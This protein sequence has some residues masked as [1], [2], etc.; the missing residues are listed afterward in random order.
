MDLLSKAHNLIEINVNKHR[1][2]NWLIYPFRWNSAIQESNVYYW[3]YLIIK[4][5]NNDY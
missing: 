3:C 2:G 1:S 5:G 4:E